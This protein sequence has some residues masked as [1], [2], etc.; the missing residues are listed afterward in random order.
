MSLEILPSRCPSPSALE[1][2]H[3]ECELL[4]QSVSSHQRKTPTLSLSPTIE[5]AVRPMARHIRFADFDH[6]ISSFNTFT[7]PLNP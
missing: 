5:I 7:M 1:H 3:E 2:K 4:L 6:V